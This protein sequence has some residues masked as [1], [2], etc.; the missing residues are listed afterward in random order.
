MGQIKLDTAAKITKYN[1]M[2]NVHEQSPSNTFIHQGL[3]SEEF[4]GRLRSAASLWARGHWADLGPM[5]FC[6]LGCA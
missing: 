2:Y 6:A 1:T 4:T 3:V 5:G